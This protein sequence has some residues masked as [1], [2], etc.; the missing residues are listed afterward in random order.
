MTA[1]EIK[2]KLSKTKCYKIRE[3]K[4]HEIW[5][6]PDTG[7]EFQIPRHSSKEVATGTANAILKDAG[8]R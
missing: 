7:K 2:R 1:S 4:N 5:I 6:N 3:G 8:L